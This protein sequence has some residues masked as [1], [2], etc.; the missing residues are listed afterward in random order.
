MSN[1]R[2]SNQTLIAIAVHRKLLQA[3]DHACTLAGE[4]RSTFIRHAI[5]N[6][7]KERN[8]VVQE[9]WIR[10]QVRARGAHRYEASPLPPPPVTPV[11]GNLGKRATTPLQQTAAA[12]GSKTRGAAPASGKSAT[13]A[14]KH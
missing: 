14:G 1:Q 10:A 3:M 2:A 8:G 5:V 4:D 13:R 9:D 12:A 7:I 6:V 11:A